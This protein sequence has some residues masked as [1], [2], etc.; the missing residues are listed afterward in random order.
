MHHLTALLNVLESLELDQKIRS[1]FFNH[2]LS[3]YFQLINVQED[4]KSPIS[5]QDFETMQEIAHALG[6]SENEFSDVF[7]NDENEN[8]SYDKYDA[9]VD[10]ELPPGV[11][12]F[13]SFLNRW[14]APHDERYLY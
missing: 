4:S 12:E 8:E 6:M 2:Y 10:N 7:E 14:H 9:Q 1:E 11:T 13:S 5:D 3:E